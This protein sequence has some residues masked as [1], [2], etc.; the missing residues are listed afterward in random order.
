MAA[1]FMGE[2]RMMTMDWPRRRFGTVASRLLTALVLLLCAPLARPALAA[3]RTVLDRLRVHQTTGKD[4]VEELRLTGRLEILDS[5]G[6][7]SAA[8]WRGKY[9][10]RDDFRGVDIGFTVIKKL[11]DLPEYKAR[12]PRR[13]AKK[14]QETP[15]ALTPP[16][17]DLDT[18][19]ACYAQH[20]ELD[21]ELVL[22]V[23]RIESNFDPNAVSGAGA[24][25]LMQLILDTGREMG[26]TDPFDPEQNIAGGCQYLRQLLDRYGQDERKA[27]AAYN[28]GLGNLGKVGDEV[29]RA[30][31]DVRQ[32]VADVQRYKAQYA[33]AGYGAV[34]LAQTQRPAPNALPA[35]TGR[36]LEIQYKDGFTQPAEAIVDD[37][38]VYYFARHEDRMFR[39]RKTHVAAIDEVQVGP[40]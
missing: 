24:R 10:G 4:L 32:Y 14:P 7:L 35:T 28:W 12:K 30:P 31:A 40:S 13:I 27:L 33:G 23:M 9:P 6:R 19:V 37:D 1:L 36:F 38:D 15:T 18:M 16:G 22:A 29:A 34:A 8:G 26:V 39:V 11:E 2:T 21:R 5:A 17:A 3:P 25:G 20:Y